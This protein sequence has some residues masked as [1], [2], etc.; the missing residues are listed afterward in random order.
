MFPEIKISIIRSGKHSYQ[1]ARDL[2]WSASKLSQII[3]GIHPASLDEKKR[4]SDYLGQPACK[5]FQE[6]KTPV[7]V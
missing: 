1:V 7:A 5:L 3:A 2:G 6:P 4:L